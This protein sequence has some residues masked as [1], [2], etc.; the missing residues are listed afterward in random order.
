[1]EYPKT[2]NDCLKLQSRHRRN[3]DYIKLGNNTYL[4]RADEDTFHIKFYRT[5]IVTF[6][7]NSLRT[8]RCGGWYTRSTA[9][10]LYE[11]GIYLSLFCGS[12]VIAIEDRLYWFKEGITLWPQTMGEFVLYEGEC[13][14]PINEEETRK[15]Y[16]KHRYQHRWKK[17]RY[18]LSDCY[19]SASRSI[20]TKINNRLACPSCA[21]KMPGLQ[22]AAP[23]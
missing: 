7:S 20:M 9:N 10:R 6:H 3:K 5:N 2:F 12:P 15:E 17:C 1:M 16:A 23:K 21:A 8:I 11:A 14:T 18:K 13:Q 19:E 22:F 4:I